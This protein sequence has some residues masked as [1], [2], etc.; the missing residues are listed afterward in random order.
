MGELTKETKLHDLS[1]CD[2]GCYANYLHWALCK[3]NAVIYN[4]A[5][6]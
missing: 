2:Y 1:D 5:N 4:I 3:G 6:L